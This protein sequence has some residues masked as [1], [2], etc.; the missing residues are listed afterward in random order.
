MEIP[1]SASI[2]SWS[3]L[4]RFSTDSNFV[5]KDAAHLAL[6]KLQA[7]FMLSKT[8]ST[9]LHQTS[10]TKSLLQA[11]KNLSNSKTENILVLSIKKNSV[12]KHLPQIGTNPENRIMNRKNNINFF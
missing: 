9:S 6:L 8:G 12:P 2:G 11:L 3:P 1:M 4:I 7:R 10:S 5:P